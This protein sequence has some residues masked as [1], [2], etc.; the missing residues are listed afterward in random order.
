MG[1]S[2]R[3]QMGLLDCSGLGSRGSVKNAK[4]QSNLQT[5]YTKPSILY[6]C[7]C[8]L[9]FFIAFLRQA[10]TLLHRLHPGAAAWRSRLRPMLL[11]NR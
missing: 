3:A 5:C 6:A 8:L 4:Q 2:C 10:L 7:T 9:Y 1:P 11:L